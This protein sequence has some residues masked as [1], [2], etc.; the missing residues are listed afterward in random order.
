MLGGG[1]PEGADRYL[2]GFAQGL[3]E[4]GYVE[5]K[6]VTVEYQWARGQYDLLGRMADDLINRHVAV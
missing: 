6:N 3:A 1:A 2:A 4:T 5:R